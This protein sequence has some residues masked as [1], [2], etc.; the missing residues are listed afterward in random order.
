MNFV[1]QMHEAKWSSNLNDFL[2][3]FRLTLLEIDVA[4]I[5]AMNCTECR[6]R[7]FNLLVC[8][9]WSVVS[10]PNTRN[11]ARNA[12]L[13][14]FKEKNGLVASKFGSWFFVGINFHRQFLRMSFQCRMYL[15]YVWLDSGWS[16]KVARSL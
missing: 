14:W 8:F 12:L 5:H 13:N 15:L 6:F 11:V 4:D 7:N 3:F 16:L 1:K 10:W 2:K 9:S